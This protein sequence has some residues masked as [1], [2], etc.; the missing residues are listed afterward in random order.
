MFVHKLRR[1]PWPRPSLT[2]VQ[3]SVFH[4]CSCQIVSR[5]YKKTLRLVCLARRVLH[6]S[7]LLPSAEGTVKIKSSKKKLWILFPIVFALQVIQKSWPDAI[8]VVQST[9]KNASSTQQGGNAPMVALA[10]TIFSKQ[11]NTFIVC[12]VAFQVQQAV[13]DFIVLSADSFWFGYMNIFWKAELAKFCWRIPVIYQFSPANI[14][15]VNC[16]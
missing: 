10:K 15:P 13:I 8:L 12:N 14:K 7:K 2:G 6:R 4:K 9:L 16:S 11:R 1:C 3:P 5:I